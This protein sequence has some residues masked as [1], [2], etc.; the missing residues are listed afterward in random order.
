[1]PLDVR[2]AGAPVRF[3]GGLALGALA[4]GEAVLLHVAPGRGRRWETGLPLA[5]APLL[6]AAGGRLVA[7]GT[8]GAVVALDAAGRTAWALPAAGDG[9]AVP[10][11]ARGV[12][13]AAR[14][15][16]A[17]LDGATGRLLAQAA[18]HAPSRLLAFPD[19][20]IAA[21]DAGGTLLGLAAGGHLS[22]VG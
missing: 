3:A 5:S 22:V 7:A 15:G 20:G 17:L 8:D 4:G 16:V 14:D 11:L 10:C 21:L 6:A 1:V 2:P 13:V 9:G 19:L 12:V 18:G